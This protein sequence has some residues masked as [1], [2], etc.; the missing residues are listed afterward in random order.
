MLPHPSLVLSLTLTV[1]AIRLLLMALLFLLA[2]IFVLLALLLHSLLFL[3]L[4]V[5]AAQGKYCIV[6]I[7]YR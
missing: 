3:L 2:L 4:L 1:E 6:C 5:L 7:V